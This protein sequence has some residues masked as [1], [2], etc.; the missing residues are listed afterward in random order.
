MNQIELPDLKNSLKEMKDVIAS[1]GYRADQMEKI[2][3]DIRDRNLEMTQK[4]EERNLRVEK[5]N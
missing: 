5:K 4:K 1:L 2:I 3:S